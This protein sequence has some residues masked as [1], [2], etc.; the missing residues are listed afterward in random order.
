LLASFFQ[1]EGQFINISGKI[2]MNKLLAGLAATLCV[3]GAFAQSSAPSA[4]AVLTASAPSM[5]SAAPEAS[6]PAT[7]KHRAKKHRPAA[8]KSS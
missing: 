7:K 8:H 1:S 2:F 6:K 4:P 3:A 5:A